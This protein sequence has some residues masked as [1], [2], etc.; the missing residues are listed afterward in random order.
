MSHE[1]TSVLIWLLT[2]CVPVSC[3]AA[4]LFSSEQQKAGFLKALGK[5]DARY[6]PAERMIR[7]PFS[8]PGYHT[9]LKAGFVHPTCDSLEYAVALLDSGE[10]NRCKQAQDILRKVTS[11]QDQNPKSRTY[12]IWSWFLEEPLERMSPPD[13]NWADFLGT[14]L[15][16]VALDHMHR[17]PDDLQQQVKESLLHAAY[18]IRRR[19]VGP[20]YTNIALMGTYVTL[21]AGELFEVQELKDYGK[22]RLIRFYDHTLRHGSFSEYNSPTYTI[23]AIREIARM[24]QHTHD[25]D[26]R[27]LLGQLNRLA[28]SHVARHFRPLTKQR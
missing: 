9:T 8:S 28:W 22:A 15:L 18:S 6:D 19:N 5:Q 10:P 16:Q 23:V 13:W 17:L 4:E 2:L 14:Q 3:H 26:S 27:K 7:R 20:G 12:G 24:L 1:I 25:P 11:L 21:V